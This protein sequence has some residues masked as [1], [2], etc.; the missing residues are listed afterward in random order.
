METDYTT[1]AI[2]HECTTNSP[3]ILN[4]TNDSVHILTRSES[5]TAN[6]L[7]TYK[8]KAEGHIAGSQAKFEDIEQ[9]ACLPK[10]WRSKLGELV[11]NP[12]NFW[13]KW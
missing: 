2:L 7:T 11:S 10:S 13:R 9:T 3:A 1:Y 4:Y 12:D 5:V 8:Q 6:D